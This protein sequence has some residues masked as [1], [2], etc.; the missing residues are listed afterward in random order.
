MVKEAFPDFAK[1]LPYIPLIG[2]VNAVAFDVG[3]FW[4]VDINFFTLF[5]LSEH[6]V[7]AVQ[8]APLALLILVGMYVA[9]DLPP[10]PIRRVG[11]RWALRAQS[12]RS[13]RFRTFRNLAIA[14]P[15]LG[16]FVAV[17]AYYFLGHPRM[18]LWFGAT[19]VLMGATNLM[20]REY[21][22]FAIVIAAVLA[23]SLASILIGHFMGNSYVQPERYFSESDLLKLHGTD[24][25]LTLKLAYPLRIR[26]I[27]SGERGLLYFEPMTRRISFRQWSEISQV[28]RQLP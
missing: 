19:L 9:I 5:S 15:Y 7:F 6:L 20:E 18:A 16:V 23:G 1:H 8:A 10:L 2:L 27:R 26:V 28:A 11:I 12:Q 4:G 24:H 14:A 3:Y 21:R 17:L 25:E 13:R 22:R